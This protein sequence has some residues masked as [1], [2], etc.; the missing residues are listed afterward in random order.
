[1]ARQRRR[2]VALTLSRSMARGKREAS[3]T[4]SQTGRAGHGQDLM[5]H[6]RH[7][8]PAC[9]PPPQA[10]GL[11]PKQQ[12]KKTVCFA[13]Y[14]FSSFLQSPSS[15]LFRLAPPADAADA[16]AAAV[17]GRR[18]PVFRGSPTAADGSRDR[19]LLRDEPP[20]GRPARAMRIYTV[21]P[22]PA[23]ACRDGDAPDRRRGIDPRPAPRVVDPANRG[24]PV[25]PSRAHGRGGD[26]RATARSAAWL[27]EVEA[28][29]AASRS[30]GHRR[31]CPRR[32]H[33]GRA[34]GGAG[35]AAPALH[36]PRGG[37]R[38]LRLADGGE[39]PALPPRHRRRLRRRAAARRPRGAAC[40]ADTV[41]RQ[42]RRL[43]LQRRRHRRQ[44]RARLVWRASGRRCAA[45]GRRGLPRGAGR[46]LPRLRRRPR[47]LC[48]ARPAGHD[49]ASISG[50]ARSASRRRSTAPRGPGART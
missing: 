37:G 13:G 8:L 39:F 19:G 47:R 27:A 4:G 23:A 36:R 11:Q 24:P 31:L 21:A 50:T 1:M 14:S 38:A 35:R 46:R 10:A 26:G 9:V 41:G 44:R 30:T 49:G 6:A 45:R 12:P 15:R 5:R 20:S 34:R 3:L 25:H 18:R 17:P 2:P 40:Q 33:H 28:A 29:L 16:G 22:G 32:Q 48:A 7:Q 42:D 43:H